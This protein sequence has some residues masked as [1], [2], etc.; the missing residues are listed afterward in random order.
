LLG[1]AKLHLKVDTP[2]DDSLITALIVAARRYAETFTR[3]AFISQTWDLFL[4]HFPGASDFNQ[5]WQDYGVLGD[6]ALGIGMPPV[7][8]TYHNMSEIYFRSGQIIIPK[9]PLQDVQFIK[10]LDAQGDV[11]TLDPSQYVVD[12]PYVTTGGSGLGN[13]IGGSEPGRIVPAPNLMWPLTQISMRAPVINAV[14][15]R[16]DCGYGTDPTA[17]DFP[18]ELIPAMKLMIGH[19]YGNREEVITGLRAA[20][21]QVPK[22]AEM[23]LWSIK[24]PV[25]V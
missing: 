12:G 18:L 8:Y 7:G 23:L 3:R 24:L 20:A 19:W 14:Q 25:V 21:V 6:A 2:D 17:L 4:D 10:Y 11:Q 22:A 5:G 15:V 13:N 16:F 9:P 1:D